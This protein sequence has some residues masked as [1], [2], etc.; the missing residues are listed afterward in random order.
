MGSVH[1]RVYIP[2]GFVVWHGTS[3]AARVLP[4][5]SYAWPM[6]ASLLRHAL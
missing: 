6:R 4:Y 3:A 2:L 5:V 1:K